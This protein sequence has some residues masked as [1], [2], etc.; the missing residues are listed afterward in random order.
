MYK[1]IENYLPE[2]SLEKI[3]EYIK[4][5]QRYWYFCEKA[6]DYSKENDY[7]L[8]HCM[9]DFNDD[10]SKVGHCFDFTDYDKDIVNRLMTP[11]GTNKPYEIFRLRMNMFLKTQDYEKGL[12]YH[13]DVFDRDDIT[14][15]L[16]YLEDS[17]GYTEFK[18][19]KER[20]KS[21]RNRALV[22][23]SQIEHQTIMQTD[24]PI[25][26]NINI[27]FKEIQ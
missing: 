3:I 17:N 12:G 13:R 4:Y 11:L 21:K 23:N 2:D 24:I 16:I 10:W 26:R 5:P 27:N 19:T 8:M 15:M 9:I 14:T 7:Q 20:V 6:N 22:F 25:R 1:I 18:E